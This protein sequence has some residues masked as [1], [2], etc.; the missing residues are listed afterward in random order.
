MENAKVWTA[1]DELSMVV[2]SKSPKLAVRVRE[3]KVRR[4]K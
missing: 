3:V 1:C 4:Y 2:N